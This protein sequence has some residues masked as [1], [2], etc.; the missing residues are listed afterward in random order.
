MRNTSASSLPGLTSSRTVSTPSGNGD[1][2]V[3]ASS[4]DGEDGGQLRSGTNATYAPASSSGRH[5]ACASTVSAA[6]GSDE[7]V[8]TVAC[9]PTQSSRKRSVTGNFGVCA[10]VA[11]SI[12]SVL[13][14]SGSWA[15]VAM[16]WSSRMND[17]MLLSR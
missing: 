4:R 17:F 8:R 7:R 15:T 13:P 9:L 3:E 14:K 10:A 1:D 5:S 6:G 16:C 12:S 2:I 11:N